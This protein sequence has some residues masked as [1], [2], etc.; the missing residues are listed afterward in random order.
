MSISIITD[1]YSQ[2]KYYGDVSYGNYSI[3]YPNTD[4]FVGADEIN[5]SEFSQLSPNLSITEDF[6]FWQYDSNNNLVWNNI[7]EL[8]SISLNEYKVSLSINHRANDV[9]TSLI[10][11]NASDNHIIYQETV[12]STKAR[13]YKKNLQFTA[14][15]SPTCFGIFLDFLDETFNTHVNTFFYAGLVQG[16]NLNKDLDYFEDPS[17][18]TIIA[19]HQ[20]TRIN[21]ILN[22]QKRNILTDNDFLITCEDSQVP[23]TRWLTDCLLFE[24]NPTLNNPCIGKAENLLIGTGGGH[25]LGKPTTING[26][27]FPAESDSQCYLPVATLGNRTLF[28]KSFLK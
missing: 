16:D 19:N 25:I 26:S 2:N 1:L 20:T 13:S 22:G 7:Q 12:G 21:F 4:F 8:F 3:Y 28:M 24:D 10:V 11:R 23:W 15:A 6:T 17:L 14:T 5:Y 18:I 9:P 27:V